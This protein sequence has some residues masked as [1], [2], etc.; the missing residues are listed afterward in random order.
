MTRLDI[1]SD[2]ICPWCYIGH[3]RLMRALETRP[4]HDF[5][6]EWHPFQLNPDMPPEGMD[7]RDYLETKFGGKKGA[8]DFYDN[9]VKAAED[10]G[11]NVNFDKIDRTPNTI[12]AHRVIHWAGVEGKQTPFVSALFKAFFQDGKDISKHDVLKDVAASVTID[13]DMIGKLLAQD[14]DKEG[15]RARDKNAREKGVSGV[16]CF[17]VAGQYVVQGA[18]PPEMWTK[19]IDEVMAGASEAS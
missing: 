11:L 12:D 15:I 4:D 5:Q 2:P 1:I 17:I 13:P 14:V 10:S 19:V 3:A 8:I 18:Q 6:I 16:P 7:R 9:I